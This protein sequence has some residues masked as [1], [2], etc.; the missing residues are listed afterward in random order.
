V[1]NKRQPFWNDVRTLLKTITMSVIFI[2]AIVVLGK[3]SSQISRVTIV[4]L[5]IYAILFFPLLRIIGKRLFHKLG[6]SIEN[7]IIIGAGEI[8]A[9]TANILDKNNYIGYRIL[10]FFDDDSRKKKRFLRV[11]KRKVKIFGGIRHFKKFVNLLN[12]STVVIAIP[13]LPPEELSRLTNE[14]QRYVKTI[15]FVPDLKG[16]GILNT[17]VYHLFSE[18]FF[19]FKINNNLKSFSSAIIKRTFDLV[20]G[21]LMLPFLL[22]IIGVLGILIKITSP[23]PVFYTQPRIGRKGK[24]FHIIKFRSMFRD[25][26]QRLTHLLENDA[27]VRQEWDLN[28]KLKNDPRITGIGKFLRNTSLDELPQI[29]NV[30]KGEMS[31]VGPRPVLQD[32]ID[33]Y[34]K[35]YSEYYYLVRPGITGI[36]QVSGRSNTNYEIRVRLDTWYVLNWSVWLDTVVLCKTIKVV[37]NR[38][39]A[40]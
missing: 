7:V 39:G 3:Y 24:P 32:E 23:G 28:Y 19:L 36:W 16:I 25:A 17:E 2:M 4:F 22:P 10:G 21:M 12:I 38:E 9:E 34:Y 15:L 31:L 27:K 40:Y 11:G 29:F 13:S 14:I 18:E 5:W 26:D 30:I 20:V 35:D 8:G 1:Y 6:F 33:Q 37:L